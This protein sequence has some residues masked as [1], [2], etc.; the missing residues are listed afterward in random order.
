MSRPVE[1][2]RWRPQHTTQAY[3][4]LRRRILDAH[5]WRC[6]ECGRA[7]PLELHHRNGDRSDDRPAN[8]LP[9]CYSCHKA[10]HGHGRGPDRRA[11]RAALARLLAGGDL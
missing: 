5:G 10:A 9:L 6:A 1:R 8:L 4:R 11:W 2:G 7:G 3:R